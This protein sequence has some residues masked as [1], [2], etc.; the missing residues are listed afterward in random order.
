[1]T[2][3]L[4]RDGDRPRV[5]TDGPQRQ[6]DRQA[7]PALWGELVAAVFAL[8]G[9]VEGHSAVSPASSRAVHLAKVGVPIEPRRSLAPADAR[10]EP[11]HLHGVDDTSLHLVLDPARGT[12]LVD[13]GWA[14]PH[15]YEDWGTEFLVY[16]PRDERELAVVVDIVRESIAWA[17]A[18]AGSAS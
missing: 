15:Q 10:F 16:G 5:S 17:T 4:A 2:V 13:R 6:L 3:T 8:P 9:V 18:P 1:M 14:E 12:E 11:V 7:S